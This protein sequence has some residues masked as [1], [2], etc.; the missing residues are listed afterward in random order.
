MENIENTIHIQ[1]DSYHARPCWKG[2][3]TS[4][5]WFAHIIGGWSEFNRQRIADLLFCPEVGLGLNIVRYN[6]GGGDHPE[7]RHMRPGGDIPG[8]LSAE[9]VWDWT[10]DANQR[11]MLQA[12]K[13]RG[14]DLFEAFS[15]SP[16]YWMTKSGCTAGMPDGS[17]N[18]RDECDEWFADYLTEVV[19]VANNE[20]GIAFQT[21]NPLNEPSETW[22][23]E[24]NIQEG[25]RFS[26]ERQ[27]EI[28]RLVHTKLQEKGLLH[29]RISALD[30][31]SIDQ[32]FETYSSYEDETRS[33]IYQLNT[34]SY[35]GDRRTELKQ[36]AQ[37]DNKRLWMSEYC[38]AGSMPHHH[39]AIEPALILSGQI[40]ADSLGLS[41]TAW[42]YWQAVEDE[43]N[44]VQ[45]DGNWGF[46]HADFS[47]ATEAFHL[48]KKFY[49][50]AQYS[51]FFRPGCIML[52][53]G[54]ANLMAAWDPGRQAVVVLVH[55]ATLQAATY[56][57]DFATIALIGA[58]VQSY[59][60]SESE[61][62]TALDTCKMD[63]NLLS[64]TAPATSVTTTLIYC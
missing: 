55:N 26:N 49:V 54:N 39:E 21:L 9:G 15:N 52:D 35:E 47:G 45:A 16:P 13:A 37:R 27:Q 28:I 17:D 61:N 6:I 22:W 56:T 8:F 7:H 19:R 59:R 10:A 62:L 36:A 33:L 34:H 43:G 63:N 42:I 14:V 25:C 40:L 4:L 60:T 48:T 24:G 41:C 58:S 2:W 57:F 1:L 23:K 11:W 20:W 12:A 44:A 30:E 50:M 5:V 51:R 38:S 32:A 3:G 31:N 18:L 64:I 46:I 29:T 53:T